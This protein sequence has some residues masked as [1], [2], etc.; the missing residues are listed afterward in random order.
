MNRYG[1]LARDHWKTHLPE[2]YQALGNPETFFA[3]LGEQIQQRVEELMEARRP[4]LGTDYLR[5]LQ[6]LNWA[7]K[8]AEEQALHELA[9]LPAEDEHP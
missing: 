5:N 8:E 4:D 1:V 9:L 7:Q 6:G 3:E 2:R